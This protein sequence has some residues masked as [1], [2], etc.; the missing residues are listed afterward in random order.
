[1]KTKQTKITP[2]LLNRGEDFQWSL[3]SECLTSDCTGVG[4][5]S[6]TKQCN[7]IS[8]NCVENSLY[9]EACNTGNKCNQEKKSN[10]LA[11]KNWSEWSE[12]SEC[13]SLCGSG[14]RRRV[15]MCHQTEENCIGKKYDI[16]ICY[17]EKGCVSGNK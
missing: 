17:N 8:S 6:R 1:M 12:W 11:F 5:R 16:V 9:F 14:T 13:S 2:T 3:W 10:H 15:R 7:Y 4:Y